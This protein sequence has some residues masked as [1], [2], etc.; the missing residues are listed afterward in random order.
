MKEGCKTST[1]K[2]ENWG[3]HFCSSLE[4][5]ACAFSGF[6]LSLARDR[7]GISRSLSAVTAVAFTLLVQTL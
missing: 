2:S 3:Y 7:A 1:L 6:A 5:F 4:H